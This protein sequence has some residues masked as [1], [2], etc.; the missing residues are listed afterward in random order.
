MSDILA[1]LNALIEEIGKPPKTVQ[2]VYYPKDFNPSALSRLELA[3]RP[4]E[5]M[6][7]F[8]KVGFFKSRILPENML[9]INYTDKTYQ[10]VNLVDREE[11]ENEELL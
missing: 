4:K 3:L 2:N 6:V 11:S 8:G 9:L 1:D 7:I 10:V 5:P